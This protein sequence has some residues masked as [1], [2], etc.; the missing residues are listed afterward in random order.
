MGY[1]EELVEDINV[2][3]NTKA[4][5]LVVIIVSAVLGLFGG[6]LYVQNR[7]WQA[8]NVPQISESEAP[9][10]SGDGVPLET[11][12]NPAT[13]AEAN[14]QEAP[15]AEILDAMPDE[16]EALDAMPDDGAEQVAKAGVKGGTKG[17]VQAKKKQEIEAKV[18]QEHVKYYR[19]LCQKPDKLGF[20]PDE[21][22]FK[23][24]Y[25][26]LR[27]SYVDD[28]NDEKLYEGVG[29]EIDVLLE[30]KGLPATASK[31]LSPERNA[32]TQLQEL[33]GQHF[34][35]RVLCYAAINGM[36][37]AL[38][39]PYTVLLTPAEYG[40]L[41]EQVQSKGFGG[42]GIIIEL[43]SEAGNLLT[44]HDT[45]ENCPGEKAGLEAGD[46][47]LAI[48][49]VPTKGMALDMAMGKIRGP[50]NSKVVLQISREH[51]KQKFSVTVK[52]ELI[53][54]TSVSAKMLPGDIGYVRLRQFGDKTGAELHQHLQTL[55]NQGARSV[56]LDLRNN[57]GGYIDAS[58]DVC[59]EFLP[60]QRLVV[61]TEGRVNRR[62]NYLTKHKPLV[63]V[64]VVVL[65]NRFSAS[66]SE[67]TAAALHDYKVAKLIGETSFGKGSVQQVFENGD[68]SA[69]KMTVAH[70]FSPLG[71]KINHVG[72]VPD[73]VKEM[74]PRLV[75]KDKKDIQLQRAVKYLQEG[76]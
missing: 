27:A 1:A 20:V 37:F 74:Q 36:L 32:M 22:L 59:S 70:F 33:Y 43:D 13:T 48:D 8:T 2:N 14:V 19:E 64:P 38:D 31:K 54:T 58:I 40:E 55:L 67:I 66:A 50:V 39:D 28:V 73:I 16:G 3:N 34:D 46:R 35:P 47:I 65:I 11:H 63:N 23:E 6:S 49:G 25:M 15:A 5:L 29:K 62:E 17:E 51:T 60:P 57:G 69:L 56:I 7:K 10:A 53:H 42:V 24:V 12:P 4:I 72:L 18:H 45:L 41:Q 44:V 30:A 26:C 68:G 21:K 76:K 61:Y 9:G 52:R 71:H 75:G